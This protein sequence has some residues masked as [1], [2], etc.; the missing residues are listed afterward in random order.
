M[1]WF[2]QWGPRREDWPI[3]QPM[4]LRWAKARLRELIDEGADERAIATLE[5]WA[6]IDRHTLPNDT[7][8]DR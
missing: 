3:A 4:N 8:V 6:G 7:K 1:A 2:R 5:R